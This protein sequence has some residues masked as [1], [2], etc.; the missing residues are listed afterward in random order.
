M[1]VQ[2]LEAAA[3]E[4]TQSPEQIYIGLMVSNLSSSAPLVVNMTYIYGWI[5]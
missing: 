1:T 3:E 2:I 5:R 4:L